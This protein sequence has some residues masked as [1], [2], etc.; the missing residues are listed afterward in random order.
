MLQYPSH[1]IV[2]NPL[3][4]FSR[5][6][7]SQV[8]TSPELAKRGSGDHSIGRAQSLQNTR[9]DSLPN[10][11]APSSR[12]PSPPRLTDSPVSIIADGTH[13]FPAFDTADDPHN[14]PKMQ[15]G[16]QDA[17]VEPEPAVVDSLPNV[18]LAVSDPEPKDDPAPESPKKE[19]DKQRR[20]TIHA[21]LFGGDKLNHE[22]PEKK[23]K[24]LRRRTLSLPQDEVPAE[25]SKPE[26][27][28]TVPSAETPAGGAT[29]ENGG[30]SAHPVVRPLSLVIPDA[31]KGKEKEITSAPVYGRCSC[32]GRLK[33]PHGFN[34]ELSPVLENEN[35]RTNFSFEIE[36]TSGS[37]ARRSSD[38]SRDR[39]IPIIPMQV[40]QDETRQ[41]RIEPYNA[42][43]E[44]QPE[45]PQHTGEME[46]EIAASSPVRQPL[47][48]KNASPIKLKRNSVPPGFV[49]FASLHGKRNGDTGPIFEEDEEGEKEV[50]ENQP[51]MTEHADMEDSTIQ[52]R[53]FATVAN[54]TAV[55]RPD[56][57]VSSAARAIVESLPSVNDMQLMTTGLMDA[58]WHE[59]TL[60]VGHSDKFAIPAQAKALADENQ[61]P[62]QDVSQSVHWASTVDQP[63]AER[64]PLVSHESAVLEKEGRT[65]V[66]ITEGPTSTT[67][68]TTVTIITPTSATTT[69]TTAAATSVATPWEQE[70][71]A[72]LGGTNAVDLSL[73]PKFGSTNATG[74]SLR[75]KFSFESMRSAIDVAEREREKEKGKDPVGKVTGKRKS[76]LPGRM[77]AK[78]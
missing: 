65:P 72:S 27:V 70:L 11:S 25:P 58:L 71:S 77:G 20:F 53:D 22:S 67:T 9:T 41:A 50:D 55:D 15:N 8:S 66:C 34:S 74:L 26:S 75:P 35:L 42:P 21:A 38:A 78:A 13:K 14:Q 46:M 61:R 17:Q 30:F 76:A 24:K 29:D 23:L 47:R 3:S 33:R 44:S 16:E 68:T 51:L 63:L 32:C 40:G 28:Q 49:R 5:P 57:P 37:S 36:R 73:R 19:K 7:Q 60:A 45:H 31:P 6:R 12:Q 52:T 56:L 62:R 48:Q 2:N 69:T 1:Q 43:S 18:T 59:N 39:F 10:V 4:Y 64:L 54:R